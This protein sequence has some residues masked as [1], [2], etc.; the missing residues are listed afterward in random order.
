M[1]KEPMSLAVARFSDALSQRSGSGVG[2][3]VSV[4]DVRELQ[5]RM[6]NIEPRMRTEFVRNLKSIGKPLESKV[7]TGIGTI[8]PLSGMRKDKGR[9]GWNV[10]VPADKTLI[11]F[12]TSMSGKSLTTSLLRIKVSSPATVLVDM[13]GRSG[14]SVGEG[15]RND[16]ASPSLRRRNANRNKGYAFIA[17][18]NIKNSHTPS[19]RIWPSAEDSLPGIRREVDIVLANAFRH[20]NMKGL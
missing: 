17:S 4:M 14:R 20:F 10:G 16:N 7:K 9:L 11:Q 19:R 12:R 13:A 3:G 2:G 6:R 8:E 5:K 15:R 18:L 1:A